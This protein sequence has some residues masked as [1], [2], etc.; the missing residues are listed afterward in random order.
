VATDD[1]RIEAAVRSAGGEAVMTSAGCPTGTDRIAAALQLLESSAHEPRDVIV[2]IQ[3]DEPFIEPGLI[4]DVAAAL[5]E[6]PAWD[7]ATAATPA[8]PGERND[9]NAVKV[10]TGRDGR[11]LYFSR[12]PI[13]G[14]GAGYDGGN[15]HATLR[16][17]GLYAYRRELLERFVTWP[18]GVL[19]KIESLEQLRALER[20]IAIQVI[21][22]RSISF[23][24]D[25]PE[26]LEKAR[27]LLNRRE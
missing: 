16:H 17:I 8:G 15:E 27:A 11:A 19:E 24:I 18:P 9:P 25:T 26:D 13:P 12:A 1:A 23:G 14:Y 5:V 20:G 7:M 10:V 2:N 6:N 3:G 21:V 4:A 22:R